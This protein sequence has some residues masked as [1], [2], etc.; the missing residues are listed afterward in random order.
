LEGRSQFCDQP[1]F[2]LQ[3]FLPRCGKKGFP[4]QSG[5]HGRAVILLCKIATNP[6]RSH[7]LI[8]FLNLLI[9]GCLWLSCGGSEKRI[10]RIQEWDAERSKKNEKASEND[11][12]RQ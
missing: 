8:F 2:P 4:L 9:A 11:R 1:G 5:L 3:F 7:R 10:K 12:M 6:L